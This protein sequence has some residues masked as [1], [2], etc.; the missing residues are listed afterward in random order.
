MLDQGEDRYLNALMI[1]NGWNISYVSN[2]IAEVSI[3][4]SLLILYRPIVPMIGLLSSIREEG[5]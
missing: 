1:L 3:L 2:S 4:P 5:G